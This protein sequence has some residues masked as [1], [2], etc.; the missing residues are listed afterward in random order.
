MNLM[1]QSSANVSASMAADNEA[2]GAS[3]GSG[4]AGGGRVDP[5][6]FVDLVSL[7]M[8]LAERQGLHHCDAFADILA[9]TR[10]FLGQQS[11]AN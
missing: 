4:A 2:A 1:E 8:A 10:T 9:N 7:V 11:A 3:T 5:P 6:S